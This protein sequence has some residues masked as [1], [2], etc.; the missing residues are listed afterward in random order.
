MQRRNEIAEFNGAAAMRLRDGEVTIL[1]S[2]SL[3][4]LAPYFWVALPTKTGRRYA[5][6]YSFGRMTYMHR[7]VLPPVDERV[8]DHINNHGLD[9]RRCNLRRA[10][11]GQN[12]ANTAG[13]TYSTS[14]FKGVSWSSSRR[15]WVAQIKSKDAFGDR[16]KFLG[17]FDLEADAARAYDTAALALWGEFAHLNFGA[18][19]NDY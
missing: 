15:K 1:D 18:K 3:P 19:T 12:Q 7:L 5:I 16:T 10:T 11:L 17:R 6:S 2:D 8:T 9:N 4:A 13:K 14:T